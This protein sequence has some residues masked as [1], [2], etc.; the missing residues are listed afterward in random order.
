MKPVILAGLVASTVLVTAAARGDDKTECIEASQ[1]GQTARDA[2]QLIE[3]R[4]QF[5]VCARQQCPAVVQKDCASWLEG[6]EK[7]LPTVVVRARNAAGADLIDVPVTVDGAPLTTRLDG[8]A[9]PMNPGS[10][11]FHFQLADGTSA[12]LRVLVT[13][14]AQNQTVAVVLASAAPPPASPAPAPPVITTVVPPPGGGSSSWRTV[15]WVVGAAGVVG[16][17]VG[18]VSGVVAM[19]DKNSANCA[20]KLCDPGPLGSARGAATVSDI[21]FIGGGALLAAGV[22]LVLLSPG[23]GHEA[24]TLVR[25]APMVGA[26]GGGMTLGGTW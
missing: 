21:G 18:A 20:D 9:I 6:V 3:A 5:R 19:N 2:H 14:G 7:S 4:E 13:E 15:G 16:L 8:Q 1:K 26:S 17:A 23:A 10:H 11:A 24:A 22:A 12:D 25:V